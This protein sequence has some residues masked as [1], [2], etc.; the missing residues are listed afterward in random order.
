MIYHLLFI[1]FIIESCLSVQGQNLSD[2]LKKN[3]V[4]H[5]YK[6]DSLNLNK[7]K[8]NKGGY[9]FTNSKGQTTLTLPKGTI[10]MSVPTG[11]S[12]VYAKIV[13]PKFKGKT[14]GQLIVSQFQDNKKVNETPIGMGEIDGSIGIRADVVIDNKENCSLFLYFLSGQ[15]MTCPLEKVSESRMEILSLTNDNENTTFG[16][17]YQSCLLFEDTNERKRQKQLE[18]MSKELN[19]NDFLK[20]IGN[21]LDNYYI[22]SYK[23]KER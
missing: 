12:V 1:L 16:K 21:T 8:R 4:P 11:D 9:F 7:T 6:K 14:M 15:I 22:I 18:Q 19:R 5:Y 23:L 2:Y 20:K 10:N 3:K 13:S 17:E